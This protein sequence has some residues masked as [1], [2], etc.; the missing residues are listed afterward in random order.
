MRGDACVDGACRVGRAPTEVCANG[1]D[2]D[3]NGI[4]D[5]F[6]V[7][8]VVRF[9]DWAEDV[10]VADGLAYVGVQQA[11]LRVVELNPH[12]G[13]EEKG[14]Y[15]PDFCPGRLDS[16]EFWVDDVEV[17][18]ER[19][20]AHLASGPCGLVIVNVVN[21]EEDPF[22]VAV[23]DTEGWTEDARAVGDLVYL[24]DFNGGLLIL[25]VS[26]PSNPISL[27]GIGFADSSFGGAIDVEVIGFVAYV[28]TTRGLRIVDVTNPRTPVLIG[29]VDTNPTTGPAQDVELAEGIERTY[30]FL[31]SWQDGVVILDVTDPAAPVE[32]CT[33]ESLAQSFE[34][35]VAGQR[36]F[37]AD[38]M[39]I[40]E[41]GA[42]TDGLRIFDVSSAQCDDEM[43]SF[44]TVGFAW[45]LEVAEV[46]IEGSTSTTAH[47]A[48]G[49]DPFG[50]QMGGVEIVHVSA[51]RVSA[52]A[53]RVPIPEPSR[54]L[55]ITSALAVVAGLARL[56]RRR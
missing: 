7:C 38:G 29:A 37:I 55:L 9:E 4:A 35:T 51:M 21:P 36:A 46:E 8:D 11:G 56:R 26:E 42:A 53:T 20:L 23:F 10:E 19:G 54:V 44:Q 6:E 47:I 18:V 28:A 49:E 14:F 24:A 40:A 30:A 5:D 41:G 2:D 45:D 22:L 27:G 15:D 16:V 48:F 50:M 32:Q 13:P 39:I 52:A 33:I 43:Q 31:A 1:I 17:D 3:C 34:V 25:D 12:S